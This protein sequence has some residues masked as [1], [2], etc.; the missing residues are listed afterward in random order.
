MSFRIL[1]D[2]GRLDVY[3]EEK[4]VIHQPFQPSSD[5]S[6]ELFPNE[7]AALAWWDS[8]KAPYEQQFNITEST[9]EE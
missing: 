1:Y 9:G 3:F 2:N 4:H 5:G 8:A 6:Q 7:A